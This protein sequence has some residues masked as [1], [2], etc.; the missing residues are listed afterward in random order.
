MLRLY[1][2]CVCAGGSTG[3]AAAG[4]SVVRTHNLGNFLW[5][6]PLV[7]Y[8]V[9]SLLGC[10][11]FGWSLVAAGEAVRQQERS[12]WALLAFS[13]SYDRSAHL[14]R[15]LP[16]ISSNHQIPLVFLPRYVMVT[17]P[18]PKLFHRN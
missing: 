13:T 1:G 3:A 9:T 11:E 5:C 17:S 6:G 18:R 16:V 8:K 2:C 15:S 12:I 10:K 14:A 7:L 4:D